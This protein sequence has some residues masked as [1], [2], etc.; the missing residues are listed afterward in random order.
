[1]VTTRSQT[2][3]STKDEP[4]LK[5][6]TSE[7]HPSD[8]DSKPVKQSKK[9]SSSTTEDKAKT[10]S[11][12]KPKTVELLLAKGRPMSEFIAVDKAQESTPETVL[13]HLLNA[14]ISSARISHT[15]AEETLAQCV[16]AGYQNIDTL[17]KSSWE[18]RTDVLTKGGYTHYREKTATA[19]GQLAEH[20]REKYDGDASRLVDVK[21]SENANGTVKKR[22]KEFK[23]IGELG[24][25]I[26]LETIQAVAPS[27]APALS[28]RN[29][30]TAEK[31]GLGDANQVFE[32]LHRDAAS[33]AKLCQALTVI[34]LEGK[35]HEYT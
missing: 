26:F 13:A 12:R 19:L 6:N 34:R 33:M 15:I 8:K 4:S 16:S 1:M 25:D 2:G 18:E 21:S 23:G 35:E 22:V 9:S 30:A 29:L 27:V 3:Q 11:G 7:K 31:L 5:S 20:L 24:A 32:E 10:Q 14:L 17:E 28:Q